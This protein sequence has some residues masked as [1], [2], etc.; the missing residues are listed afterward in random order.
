M[1]PIVSFANWG[2]ICLSYLFQIVFAILPGKAARSH[3]MLELCFA[4]F[5]KPFNF[6]RGQTEPTQGGKAVHF[7]LVFASLKDDTSAPWSGRGELHGGC[8]TA[9][10]IT[11]TS[12]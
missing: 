6:F 8:R 4:L 10:V 7:I 9:C 11:V 2:F 12:A 5:V 3:N 1:G